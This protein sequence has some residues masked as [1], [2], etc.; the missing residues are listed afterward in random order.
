MLILLWIA[1]AF[2]TAFTYFVLERDEVFTQYCH[3]LPN[4]V[5]WLGSYLFMLK[6]NSQPWIPG[7]AGLTFFMTKEWNYSYKL[8]V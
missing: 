6:V 5:H 3:R 1:P 7:T 2:Y 8:A 4:L